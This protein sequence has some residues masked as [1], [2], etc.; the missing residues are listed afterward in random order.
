VYTWSNTIQFLRRLRSSSAVRNGALV[1]VAALVLSSC[2]TAR[3][4]SS[5]PHPHVTPVATN[6][7]PASSVCGPEG[8]D[9]K[10]SFDGDFTGC[11]RVPALYSSSLIVALQAYINGP[12]PP[13]GPT[14]TTAKATT[15]NDHLSLTLSSYNVKPGETVTITGHYAEPVPSPR[16]T[17]VNVCWDGCVTGLQDGG[18]PLHWTSHTTFRTTFRVPQTAWLVTNH[19]VVAVHALR[20]GKYQVGVQC[21]GAISGCAYSRANAQATVTL[22]SSAPQRCV[23]GKPCESMHLSATTA[24]VGNTIKVT[25]WA[26]LQSVIGQPF[27]WD[28]SVTAGSLKHKYPA[29]TYEQNQKGGGYNVV[30]TPQ[31]LHVA[32]SPTWA[33][34]G[35]VPYISSTFAG[36]SPVE[37]LSNSN[38]IAWCATSGLRITGGSTPVAVSTSGVATALRG[39]PLRIFSS[40]T[41]NP[42]CSTVL[43]D[44]THHDTIYAGF[45]TAVDH[46]A[47]PIYIA[48]L[49]TTDN[50]ATWRTVPTPAGANVEDFSGFTTDGSQVEALFAGANTYNSRGYPSGTHDGLVSAEVTT[51]GGASWTATTLGCP[52]SGPCTVFGP[53]EW[54]NCAMNGSPQP[55]LQGPAGS[56]ATSGVRWTNTSW[57]PSLNSCFSQQLVVSSPRD[58]LLLDTSSQY[59]LQESTDAGQTWSYVALPRIAAANYNGQYTALGNSLLFAP[60]GSL[61]SAITPPSGTS[62]DLFLLSP[63]ATSW[64]Q[65]PRVFRGT[66]TDAT[67]GPLRISGGDLVWIESKYPND[68]AETSS[69]HEVPLSSLHC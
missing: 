12:S 49:Y 24:K 39:T 45:N 38:V 41:A 60:D 16:Q 18:S 58:L 21:I 6:N 32:P 64:C 43:L 54:G 35:H 69:E 23:T 19:G 50:G 40:P 52:A 1:L 68:A 51:N 28:Y 10:Q 59:P 67:N 61:F 48:G 29:L 65:V 3:N 47:P 55:L 15:T 20:S 56:T 17:F 27:G 31:V 37:T 34:L 42:S 53:Y 25:G 9:V 4:N 11:F 14:T 63:G 33:S 22:T 30:M 62:E 57:A 36:P 13:S 46:S 66:I 26:P 7:I 44:P 8:D 5:V 2:G